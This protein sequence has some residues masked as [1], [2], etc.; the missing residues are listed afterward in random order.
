MTPLHFTVLPFEGVEGD[1]VDS[2]LSLLGLVGVVFGSD[3]DVNG[4]GRGMTPGTVSGRAG[5]VDGTGG[6]SLPLRGGGVWAH[7]IVRGFDCRSGTGMAKMGGRMK[8]APA[9]G[10]DSPANAD[11]SGR[12]RTG[13]GL[14]GV[15]P[16][17]NPPSLLGTGSDVK[18]GRLGSRRPPESASASNL[19]TRSSLS[20]G[21]TLGEAMVGSKSM[22]DQR[23]KY[24]SRKRFDF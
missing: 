1:G 6:D 8:E 11:D 10:G 15:G 16:P 17:I 20:D 12:L 4:D 3:L 18:G 9:A 2:T 21:A 13:D 19:E 5:G 24:D 23:C 7:A 14:T 22:K